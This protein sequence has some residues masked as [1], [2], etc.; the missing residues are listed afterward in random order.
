MVFEL[1]VL[2]AK[3]TQLAEAVNT[4]V[5]ERRVNQAVLVSQFSSITAGIETWKPSNAQYK[6]IHETAQTT[7]CINTHHHS[8]I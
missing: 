4:Q 5:G 2:L 8:S 3:S 1:P 6:T 7:S